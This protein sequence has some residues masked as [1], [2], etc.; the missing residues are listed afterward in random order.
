MQYSN[1]EK[2]TLKIFN[3]LGQEAEILLNQNIAPG[4]YYFRLN[5]NAFVTGIYFVVLNNG[6][7][8][9]RISILIVK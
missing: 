3:Q 8:I 6:N 7:L 1:Q 4:K 9:K 2:S 5:P